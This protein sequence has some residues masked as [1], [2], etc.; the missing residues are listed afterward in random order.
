MGLRAVIEQV[1]RLFS[2]HP[3]E[4]AWWARGDTPVRVAETLVPL[5]DGRAAMLAMC[6]AFLTARDH[7]WLA[8]WV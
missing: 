7:I 1:G 6:I 3:A 4:Q 5:V 2:A 8:D